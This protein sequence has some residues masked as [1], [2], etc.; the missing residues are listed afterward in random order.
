M[1]VIIVIKI[2][3][4]I[5]TT[6]KNKDYMSN[7]KPKRYT[8]NT[9]W[10][11][12][13][14]SEYSDRESRS[15][16]TKNIPL[17]SLQGRRCLTKCYPK[18]MTF[19]HPVLLT[20]LKMNS[21]SCA[22]DPVYIKDGGLNIQ[23]TVI[24][25]NTDQC[26]L[27][28]NEIYKLPDELESFLLSYYFNPADFLSSFYNISSFDEAIIW[29]LEND[30]LPENTIRRVNNC[31]WK[32]FGQRPSELTDSVIDY[33]YSIA[34]HYWIP[35]YVNIIEEKY[36]FTDTIIKTPST[37]SSTNTKS[38]IRRLIT[39][40]FFTKP[41]FAEALRQYVH[42]YHDKWDLIDDFLYQIEGYVFRRL[43]NVMPVRKNPTNINNNSNDSNTNTNSTGL[44]STVIPQN[45]LRKGF[46]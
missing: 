44:E 29:S 31:A 19:L 43:I 7:S 17:K 38:Y 13:E 8:D 35:S 33:Y 32:V 45:S 46:K 14:E 10:D 21:D 39:R 5:I 37:K 18:N 22:T 40:K 27:A 4:I 23:Q 2:N 26:N 25:E 42:D 3:I 20:G 34:L 16:N 28:D 15:I 1:V 24:N 30:Y 36:S 11:D 6:C 12:Y 41:F 9:K